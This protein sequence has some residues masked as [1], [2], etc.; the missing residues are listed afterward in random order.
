MLATSRHY[1]GRYIHSQRDDL[2]TLQVA[3]LAAAKLPPRLGGIMLDLAHL[4][5]SS[6]TL[7]DLCLSVPLN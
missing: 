1:L 6:K 4:H 2:L 3:F 5:P 7:R